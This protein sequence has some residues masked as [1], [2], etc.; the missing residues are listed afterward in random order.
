MSTPAPVAPAGPRPVAPGSPLWRRWLVV[1]TAGEAAG[2]LVPVLVV[3]SGAADTAGAAGL[4]VLLLAGAAE[5]ALLGAA[6]ASVL[7]R[8]VADLS[9]RDWVLRT[10][11]AAVLAWAV[12]TG[13]S[14]WAAAVL[15]WPVP[16]QA[17]LA[18]VAGGVLLGSIGV[19]QW[20]VLRRHV[21]HA[22]R[23]VA[24]TTAA[25][26]AGLAVFTAITT[27]LWQPGQAPVLIAA[28]GAVG[29]LA[30]ALT[31]A[32]VTGRGAVRLLAGRRRT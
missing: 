28:V 4:V 3:L 11:A 8:E 23:W 15:D 17:V 14:T 5:G 24:W 1:V 31:M 19:A 21:P 29:G 32:A 27:P 13:P 22:G 6:Q 20:T 16:V 7:A 9:R 12:G 26:L 10:A 18:V 25:W 2:F 30:M